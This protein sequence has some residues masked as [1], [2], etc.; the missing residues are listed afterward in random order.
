MK[1]TQCKFAGVPGSSP[2]MGLYL[3]ICSCACVNEL[4]GFWELMGSR[5]FSSVCFLSHEYW[6]EL[7]CS[8]ALLYKEIYKVQF[9]KRLKNLFFDNEKYTQSFK[10]ILWGF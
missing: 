8:T 1:L 7:E 6:E 2:T 4:E 10:P 3:L 5:W 9:W